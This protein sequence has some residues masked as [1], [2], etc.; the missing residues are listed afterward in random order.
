MDKD[1]K[2]MLKKVI[3]YDILIS[4]I[5]LVV[6]LALFRNYVYVLIIGLIMAVINFILNAV[7]TNYIIRLGGNTSFYILGAMLRIV[8]TAAVVVLLAENNIYNVIAFLI[9]YSSHYVAVFYFG[10][11]RR[12]ARKGK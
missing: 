3:I 6:S 1:T 12:I 2:E 8:A 5:I 4:V 10:A 7:I 11:T 9:G